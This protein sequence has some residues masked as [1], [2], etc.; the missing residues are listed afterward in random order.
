MSVV[1]RRSSLADE[2]DAH[3]VAAEP[4]RIPTLQVTGLH[5]RF[6]QTAALQGINFSVAA[7]EL[8]SLLGPSGCGKTTLLRAIAGF[9]EQDGGDIA[10]NGALM[11]GVPSHRR[12]IG[13]VFQHYALFPHL[14]VFDNVAYGLRSRGFSGDELR[15]K[16]ARALDRVRLAGLEQRRPHEISGGQKQRVALA[17]ALVIE[18]SL[19]LLDE[20]LSNLDAKLR[21]HLRRDIRLL[22][23]EL[24]ITTVYVTHD[25]EEAL[26]LSD[27]LVVMNRGTMLQIGPPA[28][29]YHN[30]G[31]RFVAEFLGETTFL[32]GTL[33]DGPA[34]SYAELDCGA[35]FAAPRSGTVDLPIVAAVRAECFRICD[36]NAPADGG[37]IRIAAKPL[38]LAFHGAYW[39]AEFEVEDNA[40]PIPMRL[41]NGPAVTDLK[42]GQTM[43][44][45]FPAHAVSFFSQANDE[46][47][48]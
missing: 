4:A 33:R 9:V 29:L 7:G 24:G 27:K 19:L 6:G 16:V 1:L 30:P 43:E 37:W 45:E 15:G 31:H 35:T 47:I 48:A 11:T 25:Q 2:R 34:G 14:T 20:P 41:P 38:L 26:A 17:R 12:N 42:R 40:A 13:I 39:R 28:E 22:Q 5:K 8:C 10:I 23:Q 36:R 3:R 44:L 18:P 32:K 21:I 46:R